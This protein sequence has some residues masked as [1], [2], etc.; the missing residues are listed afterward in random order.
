MP[1]IGGKSPMQKV[2]DNT[3]K[4]TISQK[5]HE[6]VIELASL[7]L[8]GA[9]PTNEEI[10]AAAKLMNAFYR[11]AAFDMRLF[12]IENDGEIYNKNIVE[13]M[14]V[15]RDRWLAQ[16]NK[17]FSEYGLHISYAWI[18]P[19]ICRY[20]NEHGG[21]SGDIIETYFYHIDI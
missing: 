13:K 8:D 21:E 9:S 18:L 14:R 17:R 1:S 4:K 2:E 19:R 11:Y 7:N 10:S 5:R 6:Q 12:R 15:R 16:L 20:T 3:M